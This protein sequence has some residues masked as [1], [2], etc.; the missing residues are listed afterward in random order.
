M[1]GETRSNICFG[2]KM[3]K[4]IQTLVKKICLRRTGIE[5]MANAWEAFMLPLHQR[6]ILWKL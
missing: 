6:R 5:P 3:Q 4:L 2:E 1:H